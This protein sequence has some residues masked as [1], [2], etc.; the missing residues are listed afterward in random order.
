[1]KRR[2]WALLLAW[3]ALLA[4]GAVW[5]QTHLEVSGDLRLFM[6]TPRDEA[7]SLLLQNV[8]ESPASRLQLLAVSNSDA[9]S[10]ARISTQFAERLAAAPEFAFVTNGAQAPL[11]IPEHL[12]AYR[13]LISDSFD[14]QPLDA[15]RLAA[16]LAERADDM[17]SPAAGFLEQWLP[18]DPTLEIMKLAADWSPAN[19]P[20]RLGGVWFSAGGK[21]ALLIAQ[22]R[23]AA[24][25]PDGQSK[26]LDRLRAEFEIA[27]GSTAATLVISGTGYF[28]SIIKN[29]TQR[30]AASFGAAATLGLVL[31]IGFAFR[32]PGFVVLGALPLLS[33]GLAGLVAVASLFD[34]VH[35]ITLAF[36]F[37]L[38]G[39]AQDYP[40]H[41]FSHLRPGASPDATARGVWPPLMTGVASTCI[42]YLA[43]LASG[44][45][46]LAQLACLTI[47][48]LAVA[49]LTT[50]FLLPRLIGA[51]TRDAADIPFLSRIDAVIERLPRPLWT[52]WALP[53]LCAAI[54]FWRQDGF[55]E[56]DLSRLTP[57]P[58]ELLRTDVA[59]RREMA[60]P[61]LR[62]LLVVSD[63]SEQKVLERLEAIQ[64]S[65]AAAVSSGYMDT[66]EDSSHYLPSEAVQRRRQLALPEPDVLRRTLTS[67][68][69]DLPFEDRLFEP[70][71]ADIALA[72]TLP[73]LTRADL[74]GS[75]LDLRV[76]NGLFER[77]GRWHG[78][79]SFFGV[80]DPAALAGVFAQQPGTLFLDLK[81]A[82]ESLVTSQRSRMILCLAI[83]AVLLVAVIAVALRRWNRVVRVLAPMILTTLLILAIL[84]GADVSL[85]LFHIISLVLA[86]GLGLDYALFFEHASTDRRAQKRTLHALLVCAASTLLVFAL[87]TLSSVPVL[88]AIGV[89]V[90]LGVVGNFLLAA[91]LSREKAR[92]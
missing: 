55:W 91:L 27:R 88:R 8:G 14:A 35:G 56:N 41:L 31:L 25:D 13:Y 49:A 22:T 43:F 51:V 23:A 85:N 59:L 20:Q 52:L 77:S 48:G 7:Q 69:A 60:T 19:E 54:L 28:S 11:A 83:A 50:R 15:I 71:L 53:L 21:Q 65:L 80:R 17:S 90:T 42:A 40:M 32:K 82:S 44:V 37:T 79:V 75:P 18:R 36:G 84:R 72:R 73:P 58:P 26:A 5:V 1:M 62:Y 30:E 92:Q 78:L 81:A 6:P 66:F 63:V 57:V 61:D 24:F 68:N 86:A 87:L 2:A 34:H 46:G 33:A 3:S 70:F 45:I 16:A 29:R 39:V 4:G 47:T 89:T 76:G 74:A 67:A 12:L 10:L 64:G 9:E 38:I